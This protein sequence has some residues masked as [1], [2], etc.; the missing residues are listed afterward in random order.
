MKSALHLSLCL[1]LVLSFT[2]TPAMAAQ[3]PNLVVEQSRNVVGGRIVQVLV[4][5]AEIKS[6]I[7]PS[8]IAMAT[9]G[10]LIGGLLAASQNASRTKKAETAI[11]PL[12]AALN[13]FDAEALSLET[14]KTGLATVPWLQAGT[15][16]LSKDSSILGK[17]AI[18]DANTA[19][20][21]AFIEY[22]Y[23]VSPDFANIRVVA[24][25][26][27]ASKAI[28]AANTDKPE[29]RLLPKNLAYAQTITSIVSLPA[30][31]ADIDANAALWSA[32]HGSAARAALTKAFGQ[33]AI[34]LPRTLAL[35]SDDISKINGKDKK[36]QTVAGFNGRVEETSSSGTLLWANGFVYV[37]PLS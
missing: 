16:T 35:T 25:L 34:L 33:I 14:T 1:T 27:F 21:I 32:D 22:S 15:P 28:P 23:D 36:R 8:N 19:A 4:A 6:N 5:Q 12:R 20:Q 29:V 2:I 9:G 24:K 13:G 17:S 10:G 26:E 31:G 3:P 18:L 30:A 37:Q 7:N 11:E